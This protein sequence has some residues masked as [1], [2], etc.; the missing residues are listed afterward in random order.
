MIIEIT[1]ILCAVINNHNIELFKILSWSHCINK[2]FSSLRSPPD[3]LS[4][5]MIRDVPTTHIGFTDEVIIHCRCL[6]LR[7]INSHVLQELLLCQFS[8]GI[9]VQMPADRAAIVLVVAGVSSI[10]GSATR[11]DVVSVA[12]AG[13]G[14]ACVATTSIP[15][16]GF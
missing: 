9:D 14:C 11:A 12:L 7:V 6:H 8:H 3:D 1:V 13:T 10:A 2:Q 16:S 4:I 15:F 5:A